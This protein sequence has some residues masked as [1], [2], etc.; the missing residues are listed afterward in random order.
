MLYFTNSIGA[1]IGVLASGFW[2]IKLVGLPGTIATA[3]ALN[4]LLALTVWVLVRLDPSPVMAPV[5]CHDAAAKNSSLKQLFLIAAFI[6]GAASF[7]Y[8]ISWIRML[9]MV[10]GATTHSFELMLSAF[11]TGLAF[12]GLWIKRR[13]DRIES[14][15]RFSGYVQLIMGVLALLTIPVYLNSYEW[16]S[17]LMQAL[18]KTDAGYAGYSAASHVIALSVMLPTTFMAGM[19]LPL[20]TYVLI[21]KG[22]GESSIGQVYAAN[23]VGAIVG[24]LV[25]VHIG[26]PLLGLKRLI[27]L[28]AILDIGLGL[29]LL[30]KEPIGQKRTMDL[31]AGAL[32]GVGV[33]ALTIGLVNV[34]AR[35]LVSGVYRHGNIN[36][37]TKSEPTFYQDGKTASVALTAAPDGLVTLTTNG[38]PDAAIQSN[39][40]KA[41]SMDEITMV[42]LGTL[43]IA[44][45]PEAT[46]IANIGMGA[47][48]T[49]HSLLGHSG[50]E[51]V[52]TIEIE[53]AIVA[54]AAGFGEFVERA[55]D[56][57]RSEIHIED[58]KT[59][60]SLNNSTYDIIIAEPSNPWVSG[61]SSL[62][63]VEFYKTIKRHLDKDGLFVQWI[64]LYEFD[65]EL[66]TSVLKALSINFSDY[67]I[68]TTDGGN[69]IVIAKNEGALP[70]PDWTVL[71]EGRL[72]EDLTKLNII[73]ASDLLVRKV[74][75]S[76]SILGYLSISSVPINSDYYPYVDLNAGRAR[77]TDSVAGLLMSLHGA[78]F[79]VTEMLAGD[80]LDHGNVS[81]DQFLDRS[82]NIEVARSVYRRL[83]GAETSFTSKSRYMTAAL[84][85]QTDLMMVSQDSCAFDSDPG[86]W[87]SITH[88][89]MLATLP[90]LDAEQ[91]MEIIDAVTAPRCTAQQE[92][93]SKMLLDVY[94]A[95]ARRDALLMSDAASRLLTSQEEISQAL[96]QYLVSAAIIGDVVSDNP[97]GAVGTW[98]RYK[99][100]AFPGGSLPSYMH[101]IIATALNSGA[102]STSQSK[103]AR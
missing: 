36:I 22:H 56:D 27:L 50:I 81:N 85:L 41:P 94:R 63:S 37:A 90:Y 17:W 53:P 45:M 67:V 46:H 71:I 6:T 10:L 13:I 9:S 4:I 47:G 33:L 103:T 15:V 48:L 23:T 79:P 91:G 62:F 52:D 76:D 35:L 88:D 75:E 59:F 60:F 99:D 68:Y 65:D 73:S 69:I 66:A 24:V 49:T 5:P 8:E 20:F 21:R 55:F 42:L 58:A 31:T 43:P 54:A 28:G 101:L 84:D 40:D 89:V 25:A 70:E 7:I 1:A 26:L 57:P 72:S 100:E 30:S 29:V 83:V 102:S 87:L 92:T 82:R 34:D 12:G 95:V 86:R 38:K 78:P 44:Y 80:T 32:V 18:S 64:Q 74:V 14:P 19:T 51:K 98:D 3:G 96:Q 77:F 39:P 93:G 11:I 97:E 2:L 16:M 61:V